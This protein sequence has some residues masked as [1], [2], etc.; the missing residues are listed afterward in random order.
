MAHTRKIPPQPERLPPPIDIDALAIKNR[1]S[2]S[3]VIDLL[4][5]GEFRGKV[6]SRI[7]ATTKTLK[8][9]WVDETRH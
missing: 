6:F 5:T 4:G 3:T 8:Y 2:R 1:M 9:Y 7:D